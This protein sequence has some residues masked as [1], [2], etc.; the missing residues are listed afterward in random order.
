MDNPLWLTP[1]LY[2]VLTMFDFALVFTLQMLYQGTIVPEASQLRLEFL[3][4]VCSH[5]HYVTLNLP[6]PCPLYPSPPPSPTNSVSS[7]GSAASVYTVIIGNSMAELSVAFRQQH[8]LAGL[9][10]SELALT[11]EG[12]WD[13][14]FQSVLFHEQ[15]EV[16]Q[17]WQK[18]LWTLVWSNKLFRK[19]KGVDST[20]A[21]EL[22]HS[23][24]ANTLCPHIEY[25]GI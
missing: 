14:V 10:L 25:N 5:E 12:G 22:I 16:I 24:L 2:T 13:V 1:V 3:R 6:F 9:V 19:L 4:I 11:L 15:T 17:I 20:A 7:I 18:H 21:L 23:T 8:F